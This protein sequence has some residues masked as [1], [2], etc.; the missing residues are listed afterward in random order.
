M[1]MEFSFI[2]LMLGMIVPCLGDNLVEAHFTHEGYFRL[3]DA[4]PYYDSGSSM[5]YAEDCMGESDPS[6]SDGF[7]GCLIVG[8]DNTNVI[9]SDIAVPSLT[10]TNVS[11]TVL[12]E[13]DVTES[14]P[15]T[16]GYNGNGSG[17]EQLAGLYYEE[18]PPCRIW[19]SYL[20]DY[21]NRPNDDDPVY[22]YSDCD[23][24]TPNAQGMWRMDDESDIDTS[25]NDPYRATMWVYDITEIPSAIATDYFSGDEML[26]GPGKSHGSRGSSLGPSFGVRNWTLPTTDMDGFTPI[27]Y[28]KSSIGFSRW[29]VPSLFRGASDI[30]APLN[31]EI[32]GVEVMRVSDGGTDYEAAIFLG[33]RA[34]Y[35]ANVYPADTPSAK[36]TES[37]YDVGADTYASPGAQPWPDPDVVPSE[38][39]GVEEYDSTPPNYDGQDPSF[40]EW[41]SDGD[42][43]P[44]DT[45]LISMCTAGTGPR[46]QWRE[47]FFYLYDV[48][49]LGDMYAGTSVYDHDELQPYA[50]VDV[51]VDPDNDGWTDRDA[52]VQPWKWMSM[53]VS[54]A[55]D[56][57]FFIHP[58]DP[59]PGAG[60]PYSRS[61][62]RGVTIYSIDVTGGSPPVTD[63]KN[64]SDGVVTAGGEI[65]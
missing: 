27:L 61:G 41:E 23:A 54:H 58:T 3:P 29:Y 43:M 33:S 51:T 46:A 65:G 64:K 5:S 56:M 53:T 35:N 40:A 50:E 36:P 37:P 32:V 16:D 18:G 48:A 62:R 19:W 25:K 6:S 42:R 57:L 52:C 21:A 2:V 22:G 63:D 13:W 30:Q 17:S 8:M 44:G 55:N 31:T 39:Y 10:G 9:M 11:S 24:V 34:A 7:P 12:A 20:K 49:E 60:P 45:N 59:P 4:S 47:T 14:L 1:R 28:Y 15:E 26:L 38:W